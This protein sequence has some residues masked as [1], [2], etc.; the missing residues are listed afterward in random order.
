M[1]WCNR[2]GHIR[3]K[4][5]Y[6]VMQPLTL[7]VRTWRLFHACHVNN[8]SVCV[9]SSDIFW[10]GNLNGPLSVGIEPRQFEIWL[11]TEQHTV[12][13][14]VEYKH[15]SAWRMPRLTVSFSLLNPLCYR[16][17]FRLV[18]VRA[19][20]WMVEISHGLCLGPIEVSSKYT[21]VSLLGS[22]RLL[23]T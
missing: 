19:S 3:C 8:V 7:A 17:S 12:R 18:I 6:S 1:D 22:L 14:R 16:P 20:S 9:F 23:C 21:I 10:L 15:R 5:M 13:K 11:R 2:D 4:A